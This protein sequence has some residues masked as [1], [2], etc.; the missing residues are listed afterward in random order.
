M[1]W[2]LLE[3]SRVDKKHG[4]KKTMDESLAMIF[5]WGE[6]SRSQSRFTGS[7]PVFWEALQK[8]SQ[9]NFDLN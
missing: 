2:R 6:Y 1:D 4:K 7:T 3:E 8:N 5:L 9:E